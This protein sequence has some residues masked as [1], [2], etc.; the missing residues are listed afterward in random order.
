MFISNCKHTTLLSI[1]Q[2]LSNIYNRK[3]GI[4]KKITFQWERG[5]KIGLYNT[6]KKKVYIYIY[7]RRAHPSDECSP[8][9]TIRVVCDYFHFRDD[10]ARTYILLFQYIIVRYIYIHLRRARF[11]CI[12]V[13]R[14]AL[15]LLFVIYVC[16]I[17]YFLLNHFSN[18]LQVSQQTKI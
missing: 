16:I 5:Y 13:L 2:K 15:N 11:E 18:I 3:F 4:F 12:L 10:D 9:T 8:W 17:Y 1:E 6:T 14:L 7:T